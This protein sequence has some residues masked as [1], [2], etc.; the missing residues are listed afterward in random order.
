MSNNS[1]EKQWKTWSSTSLVKQMNRKPYGQ[2]NTKPFRKITG[3]Q[4]RK[5]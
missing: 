4:K 3:R 2:Q 5:P 1:G